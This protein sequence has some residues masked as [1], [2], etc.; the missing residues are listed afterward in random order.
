MFNL[1]LSLAWV[2]LFKSAF[3]ALFIL[4][5]GLRKKTVAPGAGGLDEH[6]KT[7]GHTDL[8][9]QSDAIVKH[10]LEVRQGCIT[11]ELLYLPVYSA[12]P[13]IILTP[14]LKEIL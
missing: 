1:M 7:P 5:A 12:C 4:I 8:F 10:V 11:F 14:I 6:L 9:G 13:C 2:N 3:V